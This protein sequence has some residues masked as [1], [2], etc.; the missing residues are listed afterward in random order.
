MNTREGSVDDGYSRRH[1][2]SR[3]RSRRPSSVAGRPDRVALWAVFMA[4]IAMLAAAA[5]S[6]GP[7]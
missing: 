5:S 3:G 2:A 7:I 4:V 1:P 6:A